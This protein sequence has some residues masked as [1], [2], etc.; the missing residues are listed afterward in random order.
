MPPPLFVAP[1]V[2]EGSEGS[3]GG[4]GAAR[5]GAARDT[6]T[7]KADV[8]KA[9]HEANRRVPDPLLDRLLETANQVPPPA[10]SSDRQE[11]KPPQGDG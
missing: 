8:V 11:P 3:E 9:I 7:S 6:V 4:G 1:R 5:S 2:Q 10:P